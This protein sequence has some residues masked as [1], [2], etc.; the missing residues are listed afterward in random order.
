MADCSTDFERFSKSARICAPSRPR[1][2]SR[3][4]GQAGDI[5]QTK[6][7]GPA[8]N[9]HQPGQEARRLAGSRRALTAAVRNRGSSR[10]HTALGDRAPEMQAF[11]RKARP[12]YTRTTGRLSRLRAV[13]A[14]K[15]WT[16]RFHGRCGLW[17]RPDYSV[18]RPFV[19]IRALS[20]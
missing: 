11:R 5:C 8:L 20:V 14:P 12:Y 9:R 13:S 1:T 4:G 7:L 18:Y 2:G 15:A 16:L 19:A 17:V 3:E 6:S 10:R